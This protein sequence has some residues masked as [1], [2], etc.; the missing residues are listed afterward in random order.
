MFPLHIFTVCDLCLAF[1]GT[2][3]VQFRS[4]CV[5]YPTKVRRA[6]MECRHITKQ[7]WIFLRL[8]CFSCGVRLLPHDWHV[9]PVREN[10]EASMIKAMYSFGEATAGRWGSDHVC[11]VVHPW[12]YC[13]WGWLSFCSRRTFV[14]WSLLALTLKIPHSQSQFTGPINFHF[15]NPGWSRDALSFHV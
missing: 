9:H 7:T 15:L 8:L 2:V 4:H 12:L 1:W 11:C 14:S 6:Q 5:P 3:H 10:S 13:K